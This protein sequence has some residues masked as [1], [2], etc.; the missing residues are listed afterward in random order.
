MKVH[1]FITPFQT[2]AGNLH[3]TDREFLHQALRV[4]KLK[5]KEHIIVCDGKGF[6]IEGSI[7]SISPKAVV[8]EILHKSRSANE[9]V[10]SVKLYQAILKRENFELIV[11]KATEIGITEIIPVVTART[12]KTGLKYERLVAIAKE[13][14]EQSGRGVVPEIHKATTFT[15]ALKTEDQKLV[16]EKDG[17]DIKESTLSQKVAIFIGPEGGFT[18]K[19]ILEAKYAGA[20]LVTLGSLTLRGETAAI[21]GAYEAIHT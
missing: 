7:V 8:L 4:L 5:T 16:F 19:E 17:R 18:E 14:A 6:E 9:A 2:E 12:V 3:L 11:Q 10:R 15:E 1:R 21:V 13:A 20:T